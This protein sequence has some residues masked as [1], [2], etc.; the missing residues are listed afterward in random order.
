MS[1]APQ[2]DAQSVIEQGTELAGSLASRRPVVV[3]GRVEGQIEAPRLEVA[4]TGSL[5]GTIR[6]AHLSGRVE[7]GELILS[8][9]V[10]RSTVIKADRLQVELSR[11]GAP[12]GLTLGECTFEVGEE[13]SKARRDAPVPRSSLVA[14]GISLL[15]SCAPRTSTLDDDRGAAK[16]ERESARPGA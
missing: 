10:G 8:G 13:P 4:K 5:E 9:S 3:N 16:S 11:N 2:A 7:A 12:A 14:P 6:A 15:P 1:D